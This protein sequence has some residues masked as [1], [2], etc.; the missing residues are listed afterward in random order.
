M[1]SH[2]TVLFVTICA[3]LIALPAA[4]D[5]FFTATATSETGEP[6]ESE[7]LVC[8]VRPAFGGKAIRFWAFA[9]ETPIGVTRGKRFTCGLVPAGEHIFW[10][11]GENLSAKT[12]TVEAGT[13]TFIKQAVRMGGLKARVK[14]VLLSEQEGLEALA[15]CKKRTELTAAGTARA[16][17]I[18][19]EKWG[20]AQEKAAEGDAEEEDQVD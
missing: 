17:E 5:D 18:A 10:S 2:R 20:R 4:A 9:D 8:F 11:K 16:Q 1:K 3:L 12:L 19:A 13:T 6:T 7:A 15:K 14:L